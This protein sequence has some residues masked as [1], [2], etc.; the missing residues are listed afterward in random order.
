MHVAE[1]TGRCIVSAGPTVCRVLSQHGFSDFGDRPRL[2]FSATSAFSGTS[3]T[4]ALNYKLRAAPTTAMKCQPAS[5]TTLPRHLP[6]A[7]LVHGTRL[8]QRFQSG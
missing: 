1:K 7:G 6:M 2:L 3:A 8:T 5:R 4:S